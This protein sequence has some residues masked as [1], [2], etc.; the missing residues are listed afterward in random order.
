MGGFM[1]AHPWA[2]KPVY[3]GRGGGRHGG[4]NTRQLVT[5]HLQSGSRGSWKDAGAQI[6]LSFFHTSTCIPQYTRGDQRTSLWRWLSF[7]GSNFSPQVWWQAPLLTELLPFL[8]SRGPSKDSCCPRS[9]GW[10]FPSQSNTFGNS[11]IYMPL[12]VSPG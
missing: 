12:G 5:V 6:K 7:Q 11:L 4:R 10:I 1:W 9:S 8:V 3:L 2:T